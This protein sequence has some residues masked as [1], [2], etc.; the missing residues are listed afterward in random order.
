MLQIS[1]VFVPWAL[2]R[3]VLPFKDSGEAAEPSCATPSATKLS[4]TARRSE[5]PPR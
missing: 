2:R 3:V 1:Q 4:P 5:A